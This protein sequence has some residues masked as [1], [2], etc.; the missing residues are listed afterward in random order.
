MGECTHKFDLEERTS[1]F[2][3]KVICFLKNVPETTI[4]RPIINQL[5][6][7]STSIGAN[8]ME[9]DCAESRR[10]FRHKISICKKES[11]ETMHWFRMVMEIIPKN[12]K[13]QCKEYKQE[14]KELTLIF[15]K[16]IHSCD[17]KKG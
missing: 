12:M 6:K 3:K 9:A 11:K 17:K 14:A 10:D 13:E 5:V 2:G 8:Y 4:S 7:S 1:D 15:S 16:I